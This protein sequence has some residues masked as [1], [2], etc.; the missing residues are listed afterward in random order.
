[1]P[2]RNESMTGISE[3]EEER[4]NEEI[5]DN[6][7]IP[8]DDLVYAPLHALAKSNHRLRAQIVDAIK[9]MGSS[10]QNGQ[11]ETIHLDNI[12]IAYDQLRPEGDDGYSVDSLQVQVPLLSIVPVANLNVEKAE[13]DFSTEIKAVNNEETGVTGINARICAPSQRDSDFLP[14]VSYKLHIASIPATEGILR[15][16][17]ALSSSQVAKKLDTRPV[18]VGGDL[19]SDAQKSV[20]LETKKLKAKISK[21]KQLHQKIADMMTEQERLHQISKDAFEEDTYEFDKDKYLMA[22]SNIV[23][24]IMEYQEKIMNM[25]IKY[26]LEKDY[27]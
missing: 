18:A 5:M 4:R 1:M 6:D 25:E 8:L 24:R 26:G 19:G 15:L 20:L 2:Y 10:K 14:K 3:P 11:E 21:L 13:V 17:D 27:E 12:N 9:A 22:Q 7:F 23:N 16:T